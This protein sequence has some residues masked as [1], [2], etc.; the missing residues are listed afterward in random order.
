MAEISFDVRNPETDSDWRAYYQC[1]WEILRKPW[2][3]PQG[4]ER[5]EYESDAYHVMAVDHDKHDSVLGVGR[6]HFNSPTEA[7]VRYMAVKDDARKSGIGSLILTQLEQYAIKQGAKK[8]M[9]YARENALDFYLRRGYFSQGPAH[10]LYGK[11]PHFS[12]TKT[13]GK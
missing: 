13:I 4:S 11:I 10:N 9:L 2:E 6:I 3:Q 7:Q 8:I 12:M 5:D 1:R